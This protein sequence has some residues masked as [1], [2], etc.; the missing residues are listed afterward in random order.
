M[1]D[2]FLLGLEVLL[3]GM[4]GIFLVAIVIILFIVLL[5]KVTNIKK[6]DNGVGN[7]ET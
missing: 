6:R 3:Q 4:A 7:E 5:N 2:N 1:W